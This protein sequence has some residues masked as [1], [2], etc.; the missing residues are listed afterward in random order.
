MTVATVSTLDEFA[1]IDRIERALGTRRVD[2]RA[3]RRV[4]RGI[5]DDAAV[6]RPG[7]GR[8]WVVT[9]DAFV[10][11]VHFRF[12]WQ[13]ARRIG[14]HVV[15]AC[16]SDLA[17]MGARPEGIVQALTLP[18]RL[19]L[20]RLDALM[21][22]VGE[23]ARSHDCPV[24]GGNIARGRELTLTLTGCG[25]APTRRALGRDRARPGDRL[26]VTGTLGARALALA[27][28][29]REGTPIRCVPVARL[30]A[31]QVLARRRDCGAC[32]DVSDG[33]LSDLGHLLAA[34]G[35]ALGRELGA[36]LS[37]GR[38]PLARGVAAGA[39]RLGLDP[40][41]LAATGGEDY[42]LLF[43]LRSGR[44]A[45]AAALSRALGVSVCEIGRITSE[46]GIV[47][48]PDRGGRPRGKAAAAG[49]RHFGGA[50]RS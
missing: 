43:T 37:W 14:R 10:E 5:G 2:P 16:L 40:R 9:T 44:T 19:P 42:E 24:V 29:R 47:G 38:L 6:L 8:E 36:E 49:W 32:I 4:Q 48:L 33:L 50:G 12:D 7:D 1:L 18:P 22:G 39:K 31:G 23:G 11:R 25:S 21:R 26:C 30:A 13:D 20:A 46:P 28:A 3:L 17:A 15:A 41:W 34:S 27:L 45:G 35:R